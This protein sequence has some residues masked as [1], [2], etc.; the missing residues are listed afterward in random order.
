MEQR[1]LFEGHVFLE[2]ENSEQL[3]EELKGLGAPG[4]QWSLVLPEEEGFL[5]QLCGAD[6]HLGFSRG[7][8]REGHTCVVEGPLRGREA[9]IRKI[10][11]HKRL[12]RVKIPGMYVSGMKIPEMRTPE[13]RTSEMKISEMKAM[14]RECQELYKEI[15]AGLEIVTKD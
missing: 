3:L 9:W 5:R 7:Y 14:D 6:H 12:A 2:S 1:P 4:A 11:R 8:I 10:D 15:C 13:M